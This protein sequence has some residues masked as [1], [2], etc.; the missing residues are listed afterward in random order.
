MR[1]F[2]GRFPTNAKLSRVERVRAQTTSEPLHGTLSHNCDGFLLLLLLL[3]LLLFL[4]LL[5]LLLQRLVPSIKYKVR[6]LYSHP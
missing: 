1:V 2:G 6:C 5:L 3:P 4:F